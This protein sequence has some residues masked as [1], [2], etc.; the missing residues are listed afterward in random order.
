M[1]SGT[2]VDEGRMEPL[3][4]GILAALTPKDIEVVLYDDRMEDIPY[5]NPT[6]MA[7]LTVETFTARRSY[8]I[9]REFRNRGVTVVMGG[10]HPTLVPEEAALHADAVITG[11]GEQVWAALIADF[12]QKKLQK[13]YTGTPGIPQAGVFPRRELFK[14]KGYLKISLIQFSR[15]CTN[16]CDFCATSVFFKRTARCREVE[17]V[18]KE[19]EQ[20]NLKILFFVDDNITAN[21][22]KAKALFRALIPLKV[23]WVSQAA[24]DMTSDLELMDL[25][26]KSGCMGN[27][28][29]FE[30][31]N[32]DNLAAMDKSCNLSKGFDVYKKQ[33]EILKDYGQQTW[34][35]FTLGHE[36][37]TKESIRELLDFALYNKF[38]FAAFN[39][40]MPYP[41]TPLYNRL[42]RENRL[43]YNKKWWLS[44]D[45]RFNHAPFIP[46]LMSPD[47][48]TEAGFGARRKFNS[49]GSILKR[50][51]DRR[52][53]M[54]SLFKLFTYFQYNPLF[55]KE[56]YKKQG[57]KLGVK[58]GR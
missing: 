13:Y 44:G 38:A 46:R 55:R 52:T 1:L 17:A 50:S 30:S 32:K 35:A 28:V 39:V 47:E 49:M 4:L 31:I 37:D 9:A 33:I 2:Y 7:A 48:L 40:L 36:K 41:G 25:M 58:N 18:V 3:Q 34:A 21:P 24:L 29:G 19:I 5:D 43:L 42:D 6:D 11:D 16:K 22:E 20:S 8:E 45:F 27:V 53:H 54:K 23:K 12:R 26:E 56:V 14:S 10:M 15:G 57:M 51:F